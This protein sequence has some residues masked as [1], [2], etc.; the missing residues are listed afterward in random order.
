MQHEFFAAK[1]G[2]VD[3]RSRSSM[4][5]FLKNHFRYSTMNSWNGMHSYANCVKVHRIGLSS[6]QVDKAFEIMDTEG[7][8]DEVNMALEDFTEEMDGRWTIGFNG[9][10]S[11]YLVLYESY[12]QESEHKSRCRTCGQL[13]FKKVAVLPNDAN[14]AV[15]AQ[16]ILNNDGC[17]R[18]EVYLGQSAVVA[19]DL[20]DEK[21]LGIITRLIRQLKGS[22][23][24]NRCGRCGAE[25]EHG[26]VNMTHGLRQLQ[27]RSGG[28]DQEADFDDW[29]ME[30]LRAR[31][32]LIRKFDQACD[33]AREIFIEVLSSCSIVEETI[34]V[35]KLI[36]RLSCASL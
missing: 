35:P 20:S 12:Y 29:S 32:D 7:W 34:M 4:E 26:R 13:N 6:A 8:T 24:G 19:L 5:G 18:P 33:S 31:V 25:G 30:A 28:I 21:K 1:N 9:R 16:E 14:E 3:R 11:G 15:I 2:T 10:S 22:S 23:N 17:W 36:R 27:I